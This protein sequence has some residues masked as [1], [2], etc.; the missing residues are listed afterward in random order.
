MRSQVGHLEKGLPDQPKPRSKK[1]TQTEKEASQHPQED[2]QKGE[3]QHPVDPD[4]DVEILESEQPAIEIIDIWSGTEEEH[5]D[6]AQE[7]GKKCLRHMT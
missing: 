2:P 3:H 4:L 1:C 7:G 6:G 5:D